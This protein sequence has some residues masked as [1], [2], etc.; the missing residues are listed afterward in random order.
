MVCHCRHMGGAALMRRGGAIVFGGGRAWSLSFCSLVPAVAY[1]LRCC[2]AKASAPCGTRRTRASPPERHAG[3]ARAGFRAHRDRDMHIAR[4]R[5]HV[6]VPP[7][8]HER[9]LEGE[10][11]EEHGGARADGGGVGLA[12]EGQR[13]ERAALPDQRRGVLRGFAVRARGGRGR[14]RSRELWE[15]ERA[16]TGRSGKRSHFLTS[17]AWLV[18]ILAQIA[19]CF[20]ARTFLSSIALVGLLCFSA[21]AGQARMKACD[22]GPMGECPGR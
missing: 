9:E 5:A 11:L 1:S 22:K 15:E 3:A 8:E 20:L 10:K 14:R 6:R 19:R 21:A 13:L 17:E 7:A 18:W 2:C 16:R 12:D 4:R